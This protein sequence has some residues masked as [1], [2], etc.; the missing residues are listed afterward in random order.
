[1]SYTPFIVASY[2][3]ATVVLTWAAVGCARTEKTRPD[4]AIK[5]P[6]GT[7]G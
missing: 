1:M 5:S 6:P 7:H 3:I 4:K 2:V